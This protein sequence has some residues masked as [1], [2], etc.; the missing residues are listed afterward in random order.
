MPPC[1]FHGADSLLLHPFVQPQRAG[2]VQSLPTD[3]VWRAACCSEVLGQELVSL[4]DP[5]G[6]ANHCCGHPLYS[7]QLGP[8]VAAAAVPEV[9][10]AVPS[11]RGPVP[12]TPVVL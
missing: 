5:C 10:P 4:R 7:L 12:H 9:A 11:G 1:P 2:L 8:F 6:W 3:G